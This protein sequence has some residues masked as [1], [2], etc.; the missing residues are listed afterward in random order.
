M[1][2][3]NL[4]STLLL[5]RLGHRL[6]AFEGGS[7]STGA[8]FIDLKLRS[9]RLVV[10]VPNPSEK[11]ANVKM[12]SSSRKFRVNIKKIVETTTGQVIISLFVFLYFC[13][14]RGEILPRLYMGT[15]INKAFVR[16]SIHQLVQLNV[17][18]G[19]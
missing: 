12:G 13:W 11:Y 5:L 17:T 16:I 3:G 1:A 2:H 7:S 10:E 15:I 6:D 8:R 9:D 18:G 4:L 19:F 14:I